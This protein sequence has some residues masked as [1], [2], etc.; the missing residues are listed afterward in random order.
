MTEDFDTPSSQPP[1][2]S[3]TPSHR[4]VY[5]VTCGVQLDGLRIGQACPNCGTPV[6]SRTDA[7]QKGSGK[8][9]ASLVLGICSIVGCMFYGVPGVVCGI[10]AIYFAKKVKQEV[11]AGVAPLSAMNMTNAGKICGIIGL[12][13]SIVFGLLMIAYIVFVFTVM[14][15]QMQQ[16]YPPPNTPYPTQPHPQ[17]FPP[18]VNP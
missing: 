7:H 9:I 17:P 5:C 16:N 4:V 14:I 11:A 1:A 18:P 15:P 2:A 10:L 6:G 3:A 12:S 13:L 8:A